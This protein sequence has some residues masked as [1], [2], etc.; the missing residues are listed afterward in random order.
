MLMLICSPVFL[1]RGRQPAQE[2]TVWTSWWDRLIILK[3]KTKPAL[4]RRSYKDNFPMLII[5]FCRKHFISDHRYHTQRSPPS[6]AIHLNLILSLHCGPFRLSFSHRSFCLILKFMKNISFIS[7]F[8]IEYRFEYMYFS[9]S[10]P[11][12]WIFLRKGDDWRFAE[13]LCLVVLS[14]K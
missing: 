2:P 4:L 14:K 5:V 11:D 10:L 3:L 1:S 7:L 9:I 8:C 6:I 12:H 13:G